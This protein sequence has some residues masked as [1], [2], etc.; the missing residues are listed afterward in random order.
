MGIALPNVVNLHYVNPKVFVCEVRAFGCD[1]MGFCHPWGKTGL[2]EAGLPLTLPP[3]QYQQ[4]GH[5]LSQAWG[6]PLFLPRPCHESLALV[7]WKI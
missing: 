5:R 2:S 3:C 1:H 4:W 6:C 7:R